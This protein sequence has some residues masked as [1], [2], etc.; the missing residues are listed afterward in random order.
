MFCEGIYALLINKIDTSS[1]KMGGQKESLSLSIL[2]YYQCYTTVLMTWY[3]C[4][5]ICLYSLINDR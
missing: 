4:N 2:N 5:D 3:A 1:R